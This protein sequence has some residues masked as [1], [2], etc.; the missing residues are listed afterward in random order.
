MH[1]HPHMHP[2]SRPYQ[3]LFDFG[4]AKLLKAPGAAGSSDDPKITGEA[5]PPPGPLRLA[6]LAPP[7]P[8]QPSSSAP[9]L[10]SPRPTLPRPPLPAAFL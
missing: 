4:L 10:A 2:S 3:V 5:G 9:S 1:P 6:R 8:A 7:R